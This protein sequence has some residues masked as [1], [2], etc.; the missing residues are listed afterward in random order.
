MKTNNGQSSQFGQP[1]P[2][3]L[4]ST[5]PVRFKLIDVARRTAT[6]RE[7]GFVKKRFKFKLF[8]GTDYVSA[9]LHDGVIL[10]HE[11]GLGKTI[12]GM[13]WPCLKCGFETRD[14]GIHPLSPVLI[15]AP[16]H[17][18]DQWTVEMQDK[19]GATPIPF[20]SQDDWWKLSVNGQLRPGWYITSFTQLASN[21]VKRFPSVE[22]AKSSAALR[23]L[24][25]E[26][27]VDIKRAYARDL[28]N[29]VTEQPSTPHEKLAHAV[30]EAV[31][32][33]QD[34]IGQ[35]V[36]G[37]RCVYSASLAELCRTAFECVVIDEATKI[38]GQDTLIGIGCRL[39]NPKYR[40]VLTATPIKNR[41][42]DLFWLAWWA[43][44][45]HKEAHPRWPYSS[46][47]GEQVKFSEEFL[48]CERNLS[49]ERRD[50]DGKVLASRGRGNKWRRGKVTAEVCNIHRLWKLIGPVILRR[51][52][53]DIGEDIVAKLRQPIRVP[54]G[55]QQSRVYEY[56]L[57]ANYMDKNGSPAIGAQL[58]ALRSAA[59]APQ[60]SLL[61]PVQSDWLDGRMPE[62][63]ELELPFRSDC[64]YIPKTAACLTLLE[65]IIR[66]GEQVVVFSAFHEPLDTIAR[67]LDEAGIPFLLL[68]GRKSQAERGKLAAVFKKGRPHA[69]PVMLAGINAMAEGHSWHLANNCILLAFDWAY[70]L[71]EQG[72]NRVHRINSEK[73]VNVYPIICEGTI[74]RKLEALIEEKGNA[75]E[76]VLDGELMGENVSEVNLTEL[77]QIAHR[78]FGQ[79]T[80]ID[81][82]EL[83]RDWPAL[84]DRLRASFA[85]TKNGLTAA[86]IAGLRR[87][88]PEPLVLPGGF[89]MDVPLIRLSTPE[90][91]VCI[92][93]LVASLAA[94]TRIISRL[95]SR[96]V[97]AA[98][99][100]FW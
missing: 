95:P 63:G 6:T 68:D 28:Y 86:Q 36:S 30:N 32:V 24:A 3:T 55:T 87:S 91:R 46:E 56:H 8:Q 97:S 100:S 10:A 22:N 15:V 42:P 27:G 40:L 99:R 14:G 70:N 2:D 84:R 60:S 80:T 89:T 75:C 45:G 74:D 92:A 34:G 50:N 77:L 49:K 83:L 33:F 52:K 25:V 29:P 17:L 31:K 12:A 23:E 11:P 88:T 96:P 61:V 9:C 37:I 90:V 20:Y 57:K 81:E 16:E 71:F 43:T 94:P 41:L 66:R 72:I 64:D 48:V 26:L 73:V 58:Q 65:N 38:K 51:R 39:M 35:E 59:A 7:S 98:P 13:S 5:C 1:S 19:F 82:S 76:L 67:R 47:E 18:H 54:R 62:P 79:G 85:A 21:K 69:P 53:K 93:S 44:G 78:E 4:G